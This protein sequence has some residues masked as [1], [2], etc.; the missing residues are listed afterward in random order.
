MKST[1]G[2][3]QLTGTVD[4][5]RRVVYSMVDHWRL[6]A[7]TVKRSEPPIWANYLVFRIS[8]S[9]ASLS[10]V[11]RE[12]LNFNMDIVQTATLSKEGATKHFFAGGRLAF[13]RNDTISGKE[14]LYT[15]E[16]I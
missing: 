16:T 8:L 4:Q 3:R 6:G 13:R 12:L 1:E 11:L 5:E 7:S 2:D 14:S 9:R 10:R 15:V